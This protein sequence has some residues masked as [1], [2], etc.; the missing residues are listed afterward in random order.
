[1]VV[2]RKLPLL[3][4]L[5]HQCFLVQIWSPWVDRPRQV[6]RSPV[7]RFSIGSLTRFV[8]IQFGRLLTHILLIRLIDVHIFKIAQIRV[9]VIR[10]G[11]FPGFL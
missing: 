7:H 4:L 6:V 5:V 9:L 11:L 2:L 10:R 1:V 8:V 3:I